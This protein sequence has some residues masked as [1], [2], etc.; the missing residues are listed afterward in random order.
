MIVNSQ[1]SSSAPSSNGIPSS[2]SNISDWWT[3]GGQ[4]ADEWKQV[5][6]ICDQVNPNAPQTCEWARF[7]E[8]TALACFS[9][10]LRWMKKWK[11]ITP[12]HEAQLNQV[13]NRIKNARALVDKYCKNKECE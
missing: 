3:K 6:A 8:A 13:A 11:E 5:H 7:E 10:R 4:K 9:A 1:N 12:E 2:G